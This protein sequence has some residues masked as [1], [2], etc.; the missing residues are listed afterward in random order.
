MYANR[1]K[2][3]IYSIRVSG[4][5]FIIIR[6]FILCSHIAARRSIFFMRCVNGNVKRDNKFKNLVYKIYEYEPKRYVEPIRFV[7]TETLFDRIDARWPS[8]KWKIG[9]SGLR[10]MNS[11]R[12]CYDIMMNVVPFHNYFRSATNVKTDNEMNKNMKE[13]F[14]LRRL[15]FNGGVT[16]WHINNDELF[17]FVDLRIISIEGTTGIGI[18]WLWL[19]GKI[20][21]MF[22]FHIGF[23]CATTCTDDNFSTWSYNIFFHI[24]YSRWWD[25]LFTDHFLGFFMREQLSEFL[26]IIPT[27]MLMNHIDCLHGTIKLRIRRMLHHFHIDWWT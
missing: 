23:S 10:R 4:V 1:M 16:V 9:L 27:E 13:F 24:F 3:N 19:G 22:V 20:F 21:G 8:S 2:R 11:C 17:S 15:I 12:H 7:R 25:C 18:L 14:W 26:L 5:G 6:T